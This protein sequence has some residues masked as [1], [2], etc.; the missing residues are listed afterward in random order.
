M[1]HYHLNVNHNMYKSESGYWVPEAGETII[2]AEEPHVVKFTS[3]Q[4][5]G[6]TGMNGQPTTRVRRVVTIPHPYRD[7][8]MV[9]EEYVVKNICME[10]NM[11]YEWIYVDTKSQILKDAGIDT[12]EIPLRYCKPKE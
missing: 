10:Q 4:L 6:E 9:G 12:I 11:H 5:T 3:R 2:I 1:L 8:L 7:G